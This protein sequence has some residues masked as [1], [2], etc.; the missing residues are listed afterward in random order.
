[1]RTA[2]LFL[3][4]PFALACTEEVESTDIR[5]SGIFPEIRV[6]ARG[7]GRSVV[8]VQLKVGG[9][10]S[11]TYLELR[12]E[13]TLTVTVGDDVRTMDEVDSNT[14]RATFPVDAEDTEF[15]VTFD[16]GDED[17]GAPASTVRLPAPFDLTVTTTVASRATD[18]VEFSW[19][20]PGSGSVDW[21]TDGDCTIDERDDTADDGEA[22]I[23]VGRIET[24]ESDKDEECEVELEV[25]R[26]ASGEIDPAFTEGGNIVARQ[27]RTGSF[28][29]TP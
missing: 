26:S 23:P 12:G 3:S 17:D 19:E 8:D 16:R 14:Y 9:S 4:L 29:S 27:V 22:S 7:N 10:D 5:T 25:I 13:D 15:I 28:T 11:N 24:F 2:W 1:M 6:T 21:N 20:P 18:P